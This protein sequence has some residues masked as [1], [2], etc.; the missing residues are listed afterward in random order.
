MAEPTPALVPAKE[1]AARGRVRMPNESDDYR[2]ARTALLAEEI[3]LR[4]HIA[5]VAEQRK[6]LPPGGEVKG[7]YRFEGETGAA[8]FADLFGDKDTLAVYSFMFGPHRDRPCPMCTNLLGPL[9]GN[10]ADLRQKI[11]LAVIARSPLER[12]KAFAQERGWR[13]LPLYT[14]LNDAYSRDYHGLCPMGQRF[15]PS[16]S[17]PARTGRSAIF[18]RVK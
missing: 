4:R 10:A 5:R 17:S 14:D 7:D 9:D 1:M 18:T 12:L 16:T 3:E 2:K 15:R 8:T 11:A 13:A 6:S